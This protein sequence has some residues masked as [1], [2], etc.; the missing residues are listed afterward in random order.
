[1]GRW[2][3][4]VRPSREPHVERWRDSLHAI[5][6]RGLAGGTRSGLRQMSAGNRADAN[7][8]DSSH[9]RVGWAS[10]AEYSPDHHEPLH[11][12]TSNKQFQ[13]LRVAL[14]RCDLLGR[15]EQRRP[16]VVCASLCICSVANQQLQHRRIFSFR[17]DPVQRGSNH[18][19][20]AH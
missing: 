19:R 7:A 12:P 18:H 16:A 2:I 5:Q 1:M 17:G 6:T 10:L 9:R 8:T 4:G 14:F 15:N 13:A 11:L 20:C 3:G